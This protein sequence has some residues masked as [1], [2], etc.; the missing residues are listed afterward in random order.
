M[1][2]SSCESWSLCEDCP[3]RVECVRGDHKSCFT[4][5]LIEQIENIPHPHYEVMDN[6]SNRTHREL[7]RQS[8]TN[9]KHNG[10]A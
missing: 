8:Q 2:S 1:R 5:R 9:K 6:G 3:D 10:N 7:Y 4:L